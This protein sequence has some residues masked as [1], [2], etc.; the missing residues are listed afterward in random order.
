V[1]NFLPV[2][3]LDFCFDFEDENDDEDDYELKSIRLA[4]LPAFD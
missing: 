1:K 4:P 2:L 3:V